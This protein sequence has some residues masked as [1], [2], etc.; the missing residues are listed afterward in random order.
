MCTA[1]G[2]AQYT[3]NNMREQNNNNNNNDKNNNDTR[4]KGI[5]YNIIRGSE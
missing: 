5:F 3:H 1:D 2:I 4:V